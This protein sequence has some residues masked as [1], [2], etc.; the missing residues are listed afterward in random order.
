MKKDYKE[1][2]TEKEKKK[3]NPV[4]TFFTPLLPL[5]FW[6]NNRKRIFQQILLLFQMCRF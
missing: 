2:Q 3:E 4:Y 6:L 1:N 5:Q